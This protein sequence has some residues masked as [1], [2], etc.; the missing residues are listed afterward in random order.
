MPIYEYECHAC[1]RTHEIIQKMGDAPLKK[2]PVCGSKRIEK[3]ISVAAII[4]R[5]GTPRAS[6]QSGTLGSGPFA[7]DASP[8][9]DFAHPRI[10][11]I[12]TFHGGGGPFNIDFGVHPDMRHPKV[13]ARTSGDKDNTK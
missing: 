1:G 10:G 12:P 8:P 2:C 6:N 13:G 7:V 9:P 5:E 11:A 4:V 3:L